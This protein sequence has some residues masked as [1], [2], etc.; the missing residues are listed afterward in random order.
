[1]EGESAQP[2]LLGF[3][4]GHTE[5]GGAQ[6]QTQAQA[7]TPV[8]L[9]WV[10]ELRE[11]LDLSLPCIVVLCSQSL[12]LITSQVSQGWAAAQRLAGGPAML[13]CGGWGGLTPSVPRPPI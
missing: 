6:A 11:I 2:L 9:S 4:R 13:H 10:R 3:V 12:M 5:D 8:K 7:A 1:M